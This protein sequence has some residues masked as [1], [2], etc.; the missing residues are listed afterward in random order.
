MNIIAA[1][2]RRAHHAVGEPG[3][4]AAVGEA[5]LLVAQVAQPHAHRCQRPLQRLKHLRLRACTHARLTLR[6]KRSFECYSV[7]TSPDVSMLDVPFILA[8]LQAISRLFRL[9]SEVH[10][11]KNVKR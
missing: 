9:L 5:P 7:R 8:L 6:S 4:G 11:H 1:A 2:E 3:E 10:E